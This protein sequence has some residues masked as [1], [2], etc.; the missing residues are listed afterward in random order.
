MS[1]EWGR[2]S[3][4]HDPAFVPGSSLRSCSRS[5][6]PRETGRA[7]SRWHALKKTWPARALPHARTCTSTAR[8]TRRE[9]HDITGRHARHQPLLLVPD[10][11]AQAAESMVSARLCMLMSC[12]VMRARRSG[13]RARRAPHRLIS[14]AAPSWSHA[15]PRPGQRR[16][17]ATDFAQVL[18]SHHTQV[19]FTGDFPR[20]SGHEVH[21]GVLF[22]EG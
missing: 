4:L 12:R 1:R 20:E 5:H 16:P 18:F 6:L 21:P 7:V 14:P 13:P 9:R 19:V 10:T 22:R 11:C 15:L 3:R 8:T 2:L 17:L